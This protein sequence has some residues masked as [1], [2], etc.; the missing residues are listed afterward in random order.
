MPNDKKETRDEHAV[1]AFRAGLGYGPAPD[2]RELAAA[3]VA[4]KQHTS[5]VM[6]TLPRILVEYFKLEAER[7]GMSEGELIVRILETHR[8]ADQ[9]K[10]HLILAIER[11]T[12]GNGTPV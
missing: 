8:F 4:A 6:L 3:I 7:L 9:H 10:Q 12:C 1:L 2:P 11:K 5:D